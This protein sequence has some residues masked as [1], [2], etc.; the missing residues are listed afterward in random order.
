MVQ[1]RTQLVT[2][3]ALSVVVVLVAALG[4]L[5]YVETASVKLSVPPQRLVVDVNLTG[6]QSGGDLKT[7]RIGATVTETQGGAATT[8][9]VPPT[10]A[11]G[12]VVF[13]CK[14]C[15]TG[16]TVDAGTLVTTS[17]TLGYATQLTVVVTPTR[18][19][20]VA[21]RATATGASWNTAAN[22]ITVINNPP[23]SNL[24]VNNPSAIVGGADVRSAQ[25]I[26]QSDFDSVRTALWPG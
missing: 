10:F 25:V 24:Q 4:S 19:A 3:I 14:P 6:G 21:V 9:E 7:Q 17:R 22:T 11:T 26:Q 23:D 15:S 1:N 18:S 16:V 12:R 20:A 2:A 8:V 5:I 13:S